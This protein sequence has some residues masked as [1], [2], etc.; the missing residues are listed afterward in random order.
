[1]ERL[2]PKVSPCAKVK[3]SCSCVLSRAFSRVLHIFLSENNRR[4]NLNFLCSCR[5]VHVISFLY[6]VID[7]FNNIMDNADTVDN[8][9]ES[10]KM[11]KH[12]LIAL[13]SSGSPVTASDVIV[14]NPVNDSV[15]NM[16]CEARYYEADYGNAAP[17]LCAP[18]TADRTSR[19]GIP[20]YP[21]NCTGA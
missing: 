3:L 16:R 4:Y 8:S 17:F 21:I 10:R 14:L 12:T 5:Y 19:E 15:C 9:C 1:M 6:L 18:Q 7:S 2:I 13:D 20:T 11:K